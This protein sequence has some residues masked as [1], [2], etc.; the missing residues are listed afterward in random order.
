[1]LHAETP[2]RRITYFRTFMAS[3]WSEAGRARLKALLAGTLEIPGVKISSRDRF[4][5]IARLLALDDQEAKN[6]LSAQIAVDSG[7]DAAATPSP[8]QRPSAAPRRSAPTSSASST[9]RVSRKAGSTPR[10]AP[11]MQSSTPR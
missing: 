3:A 6:L 9:S 1:M 8:P 4:R 7:D 2:G 10:S 11:S 5:I